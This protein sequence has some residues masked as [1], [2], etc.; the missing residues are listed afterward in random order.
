MTS[1]RC[2]DEGDDT[3]PVWKSAIKQMN[4][5]TTTAIY[6]H[7]LGTGILLWL[8]DVYQDKM[9]VSPTCSDGRLLLSTPLLFDSPSPKSWQSLQPNIQ[10][11]TTETGMMPSKDVG[12]GKS[13]YH[14]WW[15]LMSQET[16]VC[17]TV[18]RCLRSGTWCLILLPKIH[19]RDIGDLGLPVRSCSP[20]RFSGCNIIDSDRRDR[21]SQ[22]V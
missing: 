11:Y 8:E 7:Q 15:M 16:V 1:S 19:N 13:G 14:T 12:A 20:S 4:N 10:R 17:V 2:N 3:V 5:A 21:L 22:D 6:A 18:V 9:N